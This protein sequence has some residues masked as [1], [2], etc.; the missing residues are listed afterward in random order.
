MSI[1]GATNASPI[2]ITSNGH[3]L[4]AGNRVNISGVLG[5]TAAN[6]TWVVGTVTASTFQIKTLAGANTTGNGV[7][8]SGGAWTAGIIAATNTSPIVITTGAPHG[9]S[10]TNTPQSTVTIS[11]V[12]GNTAAN[13]PGRSTSS[14]PP[15]LA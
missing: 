10:L 9:L 3:G 14:V 7:Y 13:E 6:G 1:T 8:T 5:N 11:G 12:T 4:I 15:R 2:V